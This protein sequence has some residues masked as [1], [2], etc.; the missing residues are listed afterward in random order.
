MSSG[1]ITLPPMI[2]CEL[3]TTT[4]LSHAA[5]HRSTVQ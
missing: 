5:V 1:V 4:P 2:N 3:L